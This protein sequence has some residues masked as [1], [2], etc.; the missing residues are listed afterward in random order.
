MRL[1]RLTIVLAFMACARTEE[2]P[3]L[4][5]VTSAMDVLTAAV[6]GGDEPAPV[7]TG[8]P[9]E[10][11]EGAV[12]E[13]AAFARAR[14]PL[15]EGLTLASTWVGANQG[16]DSWDHECLLQVTEVSSARIVLL[17]RC[18][19]PTDPSRGPGQIQ[20]CRADLR[21][22]NLYRTGYGPGVPDLVAGSTK[23]LLSQAAVRVLR[24]EG[25]TSL[26]HLQLS[27]TS[28]T[29]GAL[30][31]DPDATIN[32]EEDLTGTLKRSGT[33]TLSLAVNDT[34]VALPVIHATATLRGIGDQ[35]RAV[36]QRFT[37]LD[38]S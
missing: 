36:E 6:G 11:V 30:A 26:R 18:A 4:D 17:G 13:A 38:D 21:S 14:I 29:E 35:G 16:E 23:D 7:V 1:H 24:T 27:A 28:W 15:V 2:R 10:E 8:K 33:G 3:D 37:I 34:V 9:C 25:E 20:V 22:G 5:E 19:D 12:A 32:M 31:A